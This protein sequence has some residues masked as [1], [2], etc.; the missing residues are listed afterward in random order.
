M[1]NNACLQSEENL[2]YT[3]LTQIF[4]NKYIHQIN[5]K[6]NNVCL[7]KLTLFYVNLLQ[8]N[9]ISKGKL[10]FKQEKDNKHD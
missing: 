5:M 3:N 8:Y 10:M 1:I 9:H 2:C 7:P 6:F 4:Q